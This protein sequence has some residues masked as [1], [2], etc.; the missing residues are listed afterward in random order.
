MG[1]GGAEIYPNISSEVLKNVVWEVDNV[2]LKSQLLKKHYRYY[3][4]A[5]FN[6]I[7]E[8][9][10]MPVLIPVKGPILSGFGY[11]P[12]PL[13]HATHFHTG[14]DIDARYGVPVRASAD[15]V[16]ILT[17]NKNDG[18]G[19]Q[20][21][22]DHHNGYVTK[23]AHLSRIKVSLG[24]KVKR[25]QIIGHVGSTGL[26]TGPHLHYEIIYKNQKIDPVPF[27]LFY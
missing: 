4:E 7:V 9:Q 13:H 3:Q 8:F 21:E 23:Y 2:L 17:G 10:S 18:Y 1:I 15:G 11:R 25:G 19:N 27:L 12:H 22:I 26:S 6:R 24:Q 14:V 5:I 16:I 20:V